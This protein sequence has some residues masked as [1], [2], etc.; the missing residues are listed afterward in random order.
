[1]NLGVL[2]L[3]IATLAIPVVELSALDVSKKRSATVNVPVHQLSAFEIYKLDVLA[4]VY[5]YVKKG[6]KIKNLGQ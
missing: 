6:R 4:G 3:K 5:H 2:R 1:M